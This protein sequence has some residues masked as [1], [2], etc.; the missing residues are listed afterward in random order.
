MRYPLSISEPA[1][2]VNT[3]FNSSKL[4]QRA[5]ANKKCRALAW[6]MPTFT[7]AKGNSFSFH[8]VWFMFIVSALTPL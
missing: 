5:S 2:Y 1:H 4:D 7:R 8:C 3:F 6:A